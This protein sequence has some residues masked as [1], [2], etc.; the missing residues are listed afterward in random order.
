MEDKETVNN[1]RDNDKEYNF[2]QLRARK[3]ELERQLKEALAA[4]ESVTPS[5]VNSNVDI[6]REAGINPEDSVLEVD[7]V[8]ALLAA[9]EKRAEAKFSKLAAQEIQ[10]ALRKHQEENI[11]TTMQAHTGG[12]FS[13]VVTEDSIKKLLEEEPEQEYAL[14][15]LANNPQERG[16][17]LFRACQRRQ[18]RMAQ[19]EMI[20]SRAQEAAR[21]MRST[22]Y[23][24]NN[25]TPS[26]PRSDIEAIA[27]ALSSGDTL[28]LAQK[29]KRRVLGKPSPIS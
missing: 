7:K 19:Q 9:F 23:L 24:S 28:A 16:D 11:F 18:E 14:K 15:A 2:A 27:A 22:A 21:G 13:K 3:E 20:A 6:L 5:H 8:P 12:L 1:V 10:S 26:A 4:K 25:S 17:Y 29:L